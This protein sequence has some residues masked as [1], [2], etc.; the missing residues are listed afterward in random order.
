[1]LARRLRASPKDHESTSTLVKPLIRQQRSRLARLSVFSIIGGFAE[2]AVLVL[3]ARIALAL[4]DGTDTVSLDLGPAGSYKTTV[5][6]LVWVAV[7]L[8]VA[9]VALQ[10]MAMVLA[11]RAAN[12]V[13]GTTRSELMRLYLAAGWPLQAAQRD[14]R[15]Q[16]L[17]TTYAGNTSSALGA[18]SLGAINTFN[19][20]ALLTTA[21]WVNPVASILAAVAALGMGLALRPLRSIVR[22]RSSTVASTNLEYATAVTELGSTLQEVRV[23][24]VEDAMRAR[25][26]SINAQY[27]E[28]SNQAGYA[29]GAITVLYQGAALLLIVAA[30]GIA[31]AAGVGKLASLGA[32][33]LIALR[34][35]SYAQGVQ[36][37]LQT[38][39]LTA[40]YLES[41]ASERERYRESVLDRG[42]AP[43][44]PIDLIRFDRVDF[45]YEPDHLVLHEVDFE[46]RRGEIIGIIG[47]SGSGK[48]TLVQL[49]LRLRVPTRGR[50]LV[51]TIET[52]TLDRDTWYER[53]TFVPQEPHLFAGTVADNIRFFRSGVSPADIERAAKL[54]QLHDE[55]V[56][57]P[58]GYET[59]VGER[60]GQIS[61]GQKQRLCIARALVDEPDVMVL[62]EPTSSLDVRS[63]S[64][65]REAIAGLAPATTVFIVAHRLSTLA[66][67]DRI[68]VVL[69]GSIE[70][71]APS[72]EL[73]ESNPFYR[74]ALRLS[75]MRA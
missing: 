24:G 26:D 14:G 72:S 18:I 48:S 27:V 28:V 1:V 55:I 13:V 7:V 57:W 61:G 41:L 9:K 62:D 56:N 42:S 35:I 23:F 31:H 40:P 32:V 45:E 25:L 19:L 5:T 29:T 51:N 34:S 68:M 70:G 63:E 37:N 73:E 33:V 21:L 47:P 2:A 38:L 59:F 65:I 67:C 75:G 54:A 66:I 8:V 58:E 10:A 6:A 30:L 4:S 74:E 53:V 3:L 71:F 39:F 64:L 69:N 52:N 49:L 15:L 36:G 12:A 43:T 20:V 60:G 44:P 46:V 11:T 50:Y 16:E 17:V 22:R